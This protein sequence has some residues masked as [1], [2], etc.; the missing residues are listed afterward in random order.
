MIKA[1]LSNAL[2]ILILIAFITG[3][4]FIDRKL[5]RMDRM[6][7][8]SNKTVSNNQK[9][10]NR[11]NRAYSRQMDSLNTHINKLEKPERSV[12]LDIYDKDIQ[13]LL[14]TPPDGLKPQGDV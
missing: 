5:N 14:A 11:I 4:F 10:Q 1:L 2:A 8:D 3:M 6:W 9:E 13:K 12:W 7:D